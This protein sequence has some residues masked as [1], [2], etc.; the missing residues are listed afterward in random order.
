MCLR[1]KEK[2]T[3]KKTIIILSSVSF[4]YKT[5]YINI[6]QQDKHPAFA[7]TTIHHTLIREEFKLL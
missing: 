1:V 5:I 2:L 4:I 7:Y 6:T 3:E